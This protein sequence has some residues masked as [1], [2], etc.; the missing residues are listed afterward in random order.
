MPVV[1]Y[2]EGDNYFRVI[3]PQVLVDFWPSGFFACTH[4]RKLVQLDR[5][6][7]LCD[8]PVR[9]VAVCLPFFQTVY[10]TGPRVS[11]DLPQPTVT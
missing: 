7:N 1:F 11:V 2:V 5:I 6:E 3:V 10:V 8:A 9:P 4:T